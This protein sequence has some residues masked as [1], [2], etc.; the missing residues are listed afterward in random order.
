MQQGLENI[1]LNNK[2]LEK[3]ID[4]DIALMRRLE[5]EQR[6]E[7]VV[8]QMDELAD[9]QEQLARDVES[10]SDS[11]DAQARQDEMRQQFEELK[12][13]IRAIEKAYKE[14]D[15][16]VNFESDRSLE[17]SIDEQQSEAQ[18]QL[19][20][21]KAGKAGKS[22]RQASEQMRKLSS[23]L[24]DQLQEAEQQELA[25]DATAIR[26]LLRNLL[27]L[28][29][30]QEE[31]MGR[32]SSTVVQDPKYQN[33]IVEQNG[34]KS[35]FRGIE[36]SLGA[37]ARRQ[38]K[39]AASISKEVAE[40]NV[41]VAKSLSELLQMNQS[42]YANSRNTKASRSMQYAMTSLNNLT[43]IL[44]ESLDEMQRQMNQNQQNKR[45][46]S[47]KRTGKKQG[48][49][50]NPGNGKPSAKSMKEMQ[51]ALNKQMESLK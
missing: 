28:S 10:G 39:V 25:E 42:F 45:N 21:G 33:I 11:G 24:A 4:R 1:Q 29:F 49:C 18:R 12:E 6:V 26:Q 16:R 46:G 22:Q 36:D 40:I 20:R 15:E 14:M 13:E 9:R 17:Q 8:Q 37:I 7:S 23:H 27:R 30:K 31:L 48:S 41:N 51:D 38:V 5:M 34:I 50:S 47:C 3:Q 44:A 43:L 35:D 19:Q 32:V 2:E